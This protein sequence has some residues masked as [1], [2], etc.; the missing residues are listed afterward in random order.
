M[1]HDK[2]RIAVNACRFNKSAAVARNQ[3]PIRFFR[4]TAA[5]GDRGYLIGTRRIV[6]PARDRF[7]FDVVASEGGHAEHESAD[8]SAAVGNQIARIRD[9]R[10]IPRDKHAIEI[11]CVDVKDHRTAIYTVRIVKRK[12]EQDSVVFPVEHDTIPLSFDGIGHRN[13]K[14]R[15]FVAA[16]RRT[17]F[18]VI[19]IYAHAVGLLEYVRRISA[20]MNAASVSVDETDSVESAHFGKK[21]GGSARTLLHVAVRRRG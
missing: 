15:E 10:K 3:N 2:Y 1:R 17:Q 4:F 9:G 13:F 5:C 12:R 6:S 16:E 21:S 18:I 7:P 14:K 11:L 19:F 8:R 20:E